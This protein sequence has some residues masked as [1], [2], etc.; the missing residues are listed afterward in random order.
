MT[1]TRLSLFYLAG[2]LLPSGFA[3]MIAPQPFLKLLLT[4][5]EYGDIMPRFIGAFL[6]SLGIIV[7]QIIRLRIDTLYTTTLIVRIFLCLCFI[8][9]YIYA[10]D[11]LFLVLLGVVGLG[12]ILTTSCYL[13]DKNVRSE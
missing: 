6:I 10:G 4:N 13:L 8:G 3:L 12:I 11:P 9:F 1:K 2:Y 5:G 7:V